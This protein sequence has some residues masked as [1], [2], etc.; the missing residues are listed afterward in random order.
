MRQPITRPA[1][2]L[3]TTAA[4]LV[5]LPALASPAHA[6]P[7]AN[8]A[9]AGAVVTTTDPS[10]VS[11]DTTEATAAPA[12]GRCV[13]DR[14]VWFRF[15]APT[16]R[17]LRM[18]TAGSDFDTRLAIFRG[19]RNDRSLVDCDNNNGPGKTSA[20]RFRIV[21]G[22]RYWVAVSSCC[23]PHPGGAATLTIGRV[24]EPGADLT[25]EGARSGE[26][27]GRLF[28]DGTIACHTPSEARLRVTVS[29]RVGDAVAR[30]TTTRRLRSCDDGVRDWTAGIDSETGWAFGPGPVSVEVRASVYDGI[31]SA[32]ASESADPVAVTDPDARVG[33]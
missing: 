16:T 4:V 2:A 30:G 21:E 17:P 19:T 18:T 8:D 23:E 9:I 29:Q 3:A 28:V 26:I 1:W 13:G 11:F 20:D 25:V 10:T 33:R 24:A 5:S 12:D 7:P 31:A 32:T 6:V 14:S 22:E 27:S 15:D